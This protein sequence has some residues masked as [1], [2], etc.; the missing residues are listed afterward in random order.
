M[1][2]AD[3]DCLVAPGESETLELKTSTGELTSA[4]RS[5]CAFLNGRGGTVV[6]GA[7]PKGKLIGQQVSDQTQQQIAQALA[8]F[9]PP[10]PIALRVVP[11]PGT[12]RAVVVLEAAPSPFQVPFVFEGRAY[13]RVGTS[14]LAMPQE[15]YQRLLLERAHVQSRWETGVAQGVTLEELDQEQVLRTARSGAALGRMPESTG[16][17]V[18][19][20]LDRLDV[21]R[22][23]QLLHAAIVLFGN[24]RA[25]RDYPQCTLRLARFRGTAK[26]DFLDTHQVRSHAFTLLDEAMTFIRRHMAVAAHVEPGQLER[27]EEPAF[28]PEALREALVNAL[29]HRDYGV[30]G[31]GIN[32]AIYD[33]RLEVWSSG[34]LPFGL[35]VEDLKHEHL[36]Q[37]RNPLIAGVL[38]RHGL[39]EAWGRGTQKIVE[40]CVA[41]GHP[42]P[43]FVEQAGAVGVR[44][45]AGS[46]QPPLRVGYDLTPRQREILAALSQGGPMRLSVLRDGLPGAP[47]ER[48]LRRELDELRRL[49]LV[50]AS[51][52]TRAR[53][54][55]LRKDPGA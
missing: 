12:D 50:E 51:G 49:G 44:F 23:G 33:D 45:F 28:P 17:A 32:V 21:R 7:S 22:S 35:R 2:V 9:E 37:Q 14:T 36:S 10:A 38:F 55:A 4:L 53:I 19:D 25:L 3:L 47:P 16:R 54:W 29:S 52:R 48:T 43:E 39:V 6:I 11:L 27:V 34:T 46:Y 41:A 42:E 30:V 18:G 13:K 40:L 24:E 31:G 26:S 1:E 8:R 15:H 20:I 5:A